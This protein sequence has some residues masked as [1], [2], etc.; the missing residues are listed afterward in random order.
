MDVG[1]AD[2]IDRLEDAIAKKARTETGLKSDVPALREQLVTVQAEADSETVLFV[3]QAIPGEQFDELKL[4]CP[5]TE[6]QWESYRNESRA[7]PMFTVAPQ[8]DPDALAPLLIARSLHSIDGDL[9]TW[10]DDDGRQVWATFHDGARADLLEAAFKVNSRRSTRPLSSNAT[11]E[12]SSSGV[13]STTAANGESPFLSL[14]E[15]S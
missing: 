11:D 7:M 1:L 3:L 5:P 14:A 8:Y 6:Q 2:K 12:T 9:A 10:S 13:Q 15:G 4:K